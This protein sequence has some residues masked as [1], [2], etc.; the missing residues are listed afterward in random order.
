[1]TYYQQMA[2]TVAEGKN[3]M[4]DS[5][6]QIAYLYATNRGA[7]AEIYMEFEKRLVEAVSNPEFHKSAM[8]MGDDTYAP[9]HFLRPELGN[10]PPAG[11]GDVQT[12]IFDPEVVQ[13]PEQFGG[14]D[15]ARGN[16]A[17]NQ[18]VINEHVGGNDF[19]RVPGEQPAGLEAPPEG[20]RGI[21]RNADTGGGPVGLDDG[22]IINRGPDGEN[23]SDEA[24]ELWAERMLDESSDAARRNQGG[25]NDY[26]DEMAKL[27]TRQQRMEDDV[28]RNP[29]AASRVEAAN[30]MWDAQRGRDV[31]PPSEWERMPDTNGMRSWDQ[32]GWRLPPTDRPRVRKSVRFGDAQVLTV[33]ADAEDVRKI[34]N[35]WRDLDNGNAAMEWWTGSGINRPT[36]SLNRDEAVRHVPTPRLPTDRSGQPSRWRA[37][38]QPGFGRL[39]D[40]PGAFPFNVRER[41]ITELMQ[42]KRID[43]SHVDLLSGT[44]GD[45]VRADR[46]QHREWLKMTALVR[47]LKYGVVLGDTRSF[48]RAL[49]WKTLQ[50]MLDMADSASAA[51]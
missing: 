50:I 48:A 34:Q 11:A 49:D 7:Q 19:A 1:M 4:T 18:E 9:V 26:M 13:Q 32:R 2:V 10:P 15:T 16:Y 27:R 40:A 22:R 42:G 46:V 31:R 24:L 28:A 51:L 6:D 29:Y 3:P 45:A 21:L 39:A 44:L 25:Y 23:V 37:S 17:A 20:P 12:R 36:D 5:G 41:V 8:V 38:S 43:A 47:H 30:Q 14:T 33:A 35:Q